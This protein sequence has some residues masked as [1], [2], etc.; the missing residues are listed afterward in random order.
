ML[1]ACVFFYFVPYFLFFTEFCVTLW[2]QFIFS[3]VWAYAGGNLYL[4]SI[5]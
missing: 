5:F 4:N 3:P 2:E 1:P